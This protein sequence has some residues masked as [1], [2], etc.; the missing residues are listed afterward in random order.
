MKLKQLSM[1]VLGLFLVGMVSANGISV[2]SSNTFTINKTYNHDTYV[3]LTIRNDEPFDFFN[4]SMEDNPY[5][6][7]SKIPKLATG[8]TRNI[9]ALVKANDNIHKDIKIFGFYLASLGAQNQTHQV[10]I[11]YDDGLSKCDFTIVQ[12]DK[13]NWKNLEIVESKTVKLKNMD[14]LN[15]FQDLAA[16]ASNLQFFDSP[17]SLPFQFIDRTGYSRQSCV[18]TVL[19]D[20]GYVNNPEHDASINIDINVEFPQ[21]SVELLTLNDKYSMRF[22]DTREDIFSVRNTGNEIAKNVNLEGDWFVFSTNN[23]DLEPGQS[24][25]IGYTIDPIIFTS[26]QTDQTSKLFIYVWSV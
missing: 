22:Y 11:T 24:K 9:T 5:I 13:V 15:Y 12:G 19:S 10:D 14:T 4:V 25:N 23:F 17:M 20:T 2:I 6:T 8:E 1:F 18:L 7:I 26:N 21:T 3:N 16:Q